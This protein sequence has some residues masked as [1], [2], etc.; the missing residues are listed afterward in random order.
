VLIDR[1]PLNFSQRENSMLTFESASVMGA[2]GIVEKLSVSTS[3]ALMRG[4][5]Y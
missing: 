5:S 2:A 4:S 3:E 1:T